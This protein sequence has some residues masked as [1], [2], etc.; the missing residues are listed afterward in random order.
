MASVALGLLATLVGVTT[1]IGW[2]TGSQLLKG[3]FLYDI[4]VKANTAL[5][6]VLVGIA[7][8]LIASAPSATPP[9]ARA[10]ALF[11][12]ILAAATFSQHL[13]GWDLGIDQLL[14][15]EAQ[16]AAGTHS[17]NRMGPV[18]SLCFSALAVALLT[19]D[20][21]TR[22]GRAPFQVLALGVLL[23]ASVSVLGYLFHARQLF[24][25]A[26]Y[27]AIALLTAL[28][29]LMLG[30]GVLLARPEVGL[31]Q[32]LTGND[33]GALMM[34]RLLPAAVLV[35]LLLM[36][37]RIKGEQ[38]GLYDQPF[39]RAL[40]VMSF[41]VVFTGLVWRTG[42]VV[43]N[44]ATAAARA[45]R[46]LHARLVHSLESM[47][48]G[49]IACDAEW[50]VTY[51]NRSAEE[52]SGVGREAVLGRSWWTTASRALGSGTEAPYREAMRERVAMQFESRIDGSDRRFEHEL[53]P[54]PDGGLAAYVRDVT[55]QRR[56]LTVLRESEQL[57]R[58]LGEAVP[59]FLWMTDSEGS[60]LYQNPAWTRYTGLDTEQL[61][62]GG[63]TALPAAEDPL[64]IQDAW[65]RASAAG[66]PFRLEARM[67]RHDGVYRWFSFR[68]VPIT[69][70][71]GRV[72]KWIGTATDIDDQK[73]A[74]Q[75]LADADQRKNEFLATLAHELRNP[76]APVRNAVHLLRVRGGPDPQ[77]ARTFAVIERQIAHLTRLID[78]LMD[79]SRISQNKLELQP[80][81]LVLSEVIA[82]A[83]E[84]SRYA[85]VPERH[86]LRVELPA[87]PLYLDADS[88]RLVQV[89]T[90][91]LTNAARYSP[92]GGDITI[93]AAREGAEVCVRVR[94]AGNGIAA[95][96]LPHLFELFFQA[97]RENRRGRHGLGI[98]L[99]LVRQLV[100][101]HGG[102][103]SAT[104][105]GIGQG[106][107]FVVR[108]PLSRDQSRPQELAVQA[109]PALPRFTG[110]RV[111]V[112]ED[113]QDTA[114]LLSQLLAQAGATVHTAFDGE[115]GVASAMKAEPQ[116]V[117]LDIGLPQMSGYDVARAIR[118]T[119]WGAKAFIV[120]LTGWGQPDDRERSKQA[121]FDQHLVKPVSPEMLIQLIESFRRASAAP[122]LS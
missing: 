90:N 117:L 10:L 79:V 53:F 107:E 99:A 50:R 6:M 62:Q 111:L 11:T 70:E 93:A 54:T 49:F 87:E 114:E 112:V 7:V 74:Q 100:Q 71:S 5:C 63:W 103:V 43:F 58:T 25:L 118:A 68:T 27:T 13:F 115:N 98:G 75:A 65:Q 106:S 77:A 85:M 122:T 120:A 60:P 38:L 36:W 94:D 82:G 64:V 119:A 83:I 22:N 34:R 101:L 52:L 59:D 4:N 37:L 104:S 9:L 81:R 20:K 12:G 31:M 73:R 121:G 15:T 35:P 48:D 116:V 88:V 108:L 29:L 89:F 21:R 8:V 40:L 66:G 28:S 96:Q 69:D 47:T 42:Q 56:A 76:L 55:E 113:N 17:P 91:L 46:E 41:I 14:F 18:A 102:S 57:F 26:R 51:L 67:R 30:S 3:F 32:R 80:S 1:L 19:I 33:S 16:G 2:A 105:S 23:I 109:S 110:L 86:Q 39:A 92:A 78:D 44:Q 95:H 61:K 84:S 72:V 97:E 24:G 45:E